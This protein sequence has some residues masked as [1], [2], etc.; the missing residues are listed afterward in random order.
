MIYEDQPHVN[1][2]AT[3][4][5]HE[6]I[7][8]ERIDELEQ[9]NQRLHRL[10]EQIA[11]KEDSIKELRRCYRCLYREYVSSEQGR[12]KALRDNA[13]LTMEIVHLREELLDTEQVPLPMPAGPT[14]YANLNVI[15]PKAVIDN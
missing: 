1:G 3:C 9:E 15:S 8:S 14:A 11:K 13:R 5:E 12:I 4:L 2:C 6:Y 7:L 10:P